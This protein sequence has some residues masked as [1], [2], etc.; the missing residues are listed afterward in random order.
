MS[1]DD[2]RRQI[3]QIDRRLL[4]LLNER[5][6]V[7]SNLAKEKRSQG[8]SLH[9][10]ERENQIF[11]GLELA[12]SELQGAFPS[13]ALRPV[14][15]EI[16]SA[17]LSL[18][19]PVSVAYLG[20]P[21]TFTHMAARSRF[22]LAATYVEASTIAAVFD[23]V[24]RQTA[25]LGVVPIEN[26]TEGGVNFTLDC[27]IE[28]DVSIRS[29]L[30][31]DV[32]HCLVARQE[33]L[34]SID[35]V[36]SHPQGLAQCRSWLGKHLPHAQLVVSPSTSA[37]AR[38]AAQDERAAAV[39]SRLAAELHGLR[40]LRDSI[41]D[42]V[43]NATRFIVLAGSDAPATGNDKTSLVFSTPHKKGAL[44]AVLEIFDDEN[45]NL[46]RIESRPY[47]SRMWEYA[48]FT[49][50]EGHRSDAAV[51]RALARLQSTCGKVKVLGSYPRAAQT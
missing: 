51:A 46:T 14:F 42:R 13:S 36:Y 49:D 26:S 23:A 8:R 32:A 6:D 11:V 22:G 48:F 7:V 33:D 34:A 3:D 12:Q 40:V 10:P 35:H 29:E 1:I 4:E 18:Q 21:G 41:Q 24:A 16:I 45:L 15:R 19:Q 9:D 37:A 28:Y 39:A 27:L 5:A 44:R 47:G 31:L 25:Q 43:Q 30:V 50:V 38:Q 2:W 20:P 17:C